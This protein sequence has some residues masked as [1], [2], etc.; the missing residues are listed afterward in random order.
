MIF[1]FVYADVSIVNGCQ[2]NACYLLQTDCHLST[3]KNYSKVD[4]VVVVVVVVVFGG[5]GF[6]VCFLVGWLVGWLVFVVV[7]G[8]HVFCVVVFCLFD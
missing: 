7:V 3:A 5:V 1:G 8:V 4:F 6:F 2:R